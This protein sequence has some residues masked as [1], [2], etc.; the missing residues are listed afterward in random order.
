[1]AVTLS[2]K[3][4]KHVANFLIKRGKGIGLRPGACTSGRSGMGYKLDSVDEA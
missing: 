1:M 3:A 4:A 2:D